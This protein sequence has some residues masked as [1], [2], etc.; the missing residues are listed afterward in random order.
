MPRAVGTQRKP[1]RQPGSTEQERAEDDEPR[2]P[3]GEVPQGVDGSR[4]LTD[5]KR[6]TPGKWGRAW[7]ARCWVE[8]ARI[9]TRPDLPVSR[10]HHR[11]D[12]ATRF[13][14]LVGGHAG[15]D[16]VPGRHPPAHTTAATRP[17]LRDHDDAEGPSRRRS[18]DTGA[19]SGPVLDGSADAAT[20]RSNW[21]SGTSNADGA[22][23]FRDGGCSAR[24]N[25][26][27]G[28]RGCWLREPRHVR[29]DLPGDGRV[30][31]PR[32][33]GGTGRSSR[34]CSLRPQFGGLSDQTDRLFGG[35]LAIRRSL[36]AAP[37]SG[38]ALPPLSYRRTG[39]RARPL[40][41]RCDHNR[42]EVTTRR[43]AH[44]RTSGS[45]AVG[46]GVFVP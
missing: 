10:L 41:G 15:G 21:S 46:W 5:M 13:A 9:V 35:L 6:R 32:S 24:C 20:I 36:L 44:Q 18:P 12:L 33:A 22:A 16:V 26:S 29:G 19:L 14:R 3:L 1:P 27:P 40:A 7:R 11:R 30:D 42:R 43:P 28:E 17:P 2:I 31:A 4:I 8:T 34:P 45:R 37:L 25:N 38:G 23:A 39:R